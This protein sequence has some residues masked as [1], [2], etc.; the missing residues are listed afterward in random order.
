M[1]DLIRF[2][3]VIAIVLV[4]LAAAITITYYNSHG[5]LPGMVP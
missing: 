4:S 5:S 2:L 1:N 3:A